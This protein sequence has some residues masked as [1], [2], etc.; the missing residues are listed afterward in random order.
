MCKIDTSVPLDCC[1]QRRSAPT[2]KLIDVERWLIK[3]STCSANFTVDVI[4]HDTGFGW[5][6]GQ[7]A[8]AFSVTVR[9]ELQGSAGD[10][11]G[12]RTAVDDDEQGASGRR[13]DHLPVWACGQGHI[14]TYARTNHH[15][16]VESPWRAGCPRLPVGRVK[17]VRQPGQRRQ[18]R[19][20]EAR[21]PAEAL[22]S[23]S[24]RM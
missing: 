4:V 13:M 10:W 5:H 3:T 15:P 18:R 24:L 23:A 9:K 11:V 22:R 2:E 12:P 14:D 1:E 20:N 21:V 19:P 7:P 6:L 8:R 16:R 17:S